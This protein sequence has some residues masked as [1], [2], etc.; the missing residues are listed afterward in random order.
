MQ[1]ACPTRFFF[2]AED[3]IRDI[4][5]TGVQTCALPICVPRHV[6]E[7]SKEWSPVVLGVGLF[8]GKGSTSVLKITLF[9][10]AWF[11]CEGCPPRLECS[12]WLQR[13]SLPRPLAVEGLLIMCFDAVWKEAG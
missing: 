5:V 8:V 2:Q 7:A 13:N 1:I 11:L 9:Q 4:G 10:R 12:L 3:G 6:L